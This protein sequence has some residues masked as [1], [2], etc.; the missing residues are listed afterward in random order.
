MLATMIWE[1]NVMVR[2]KHGWDSWTNFNAQMK[3][4]MDEEQEDEEDYWI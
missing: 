3:K 1:K 4:Y 2:L